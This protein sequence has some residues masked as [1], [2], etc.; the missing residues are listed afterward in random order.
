[1]NEWEII[2]EAIRLGKEAGRLKAQREAQKA[3]LGKVVSFEKLKR[4]VKGDTAKGEEM[5]TPIFLDGSFRQL[6][7]CLEYRF[8]YNKHRHSVYGQTK[9]ECYK[10]RLEYITG[11]RTVKTQTYGQWLQEWHNTYDN[12]TK[13]DKNIKQG[14]NYIKDIIKNIGGIALKKLSGMDIQSYLNTYNDRKNTQHKILLKIKSSLVMAHNLGKIKANNFATVNIKK[15]QSIKHRPLTYKEQ[16]LMYEKIDKQYFNLFKFCCLTGLRITEALN[17]RKC[18]IDYKAGLIYAR[19]L[20]KKKEVIAPVPFLPELLD[21]KFTD[22]LFNLTYNGFKCYLQ[23]F[24]ERV[25]I[26]GVMIHNFRSTFASVCYS[27]GI[28]LKI[29]QKWLCHE[30][31]AMTADTYTHLISGSSPLLDYI[32]RLKKHLKL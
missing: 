8:M 28:P 11:K 9:D 19:R 12:K 7:Y 23:D 21:F 32:K 25:K 30:T 3:F 13:G 10:K 24:Y 31:L 18:D 27:A 16:T 15:H 14:E 2:D 29:I 20:K 1:M 22:K 6:K 17:V 26:K 4:I 5:K